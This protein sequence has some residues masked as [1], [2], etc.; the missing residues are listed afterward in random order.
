VLFL[1]G[2]QNF[3]VRRQEDFWIFEKRQQM[4][5]NVQITFL[6]DFVGL[7]CPIGQKIRSSSKAFK[8]SDLNGQGA[9]A[10]KKIERGSGLIISDSLLFDDVTR[11]GGC[12][13]GL[14]ESKPLVCHVHGD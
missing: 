2:G 11:I 4:S 12:I 1:D 6:L 13:W 3:K 7:K 5:P 14:V 10:S 9:S 8:K